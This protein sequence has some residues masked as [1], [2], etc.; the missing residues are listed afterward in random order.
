MMYN[1]K[2]SGFL[3]K[4]SGLMVGQFTDYKPEESLLLQPL[5]ESIADIVR[6]YHFPVCF[7]FPVGHV[8]ANV[9]LVCGAKAELSVGR[10]VTLRHLITSR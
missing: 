7:D 1:L 3:A 5:Y 9:P 4:L 8:T 6:E 2:L 10:T